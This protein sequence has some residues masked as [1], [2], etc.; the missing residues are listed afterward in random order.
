MASDLG[1]QL[2]AW[3]SG[4]WSEP[5]RLPDEFDDPETGRTIDLTSLQFL[6]QEGQGLRVI[7]RDQ[8]GGGD[9]WFLEQAPGATTAQLI[10]T[11]TPVPASVW[12]EPVTLD[13]GDAENPVYAYDPAMAADPNVDGRFHLIWSQPAEDEPEG[14]GRSIVYARWDILD[15]ERYPRPVTLFTSLEAKADRPALAA[16]ETGRLHLVWSG[17]QIGE[18]MYSRAEAESAFNP[19]NWGD[20]RM[21]PMARPSGSWPV[22]AVG[23]DGVVHVVYVVPLNEERGIYHTCS[24]DGG[25]SWSESSTIGDGVASG[26]PMVDHPALSIGADGTLHVAWSVLPLPGSL[27]PSELYYAHSGDC[28]ANWSEPAKLA[29]GAVDWPQLAAAGSLEVHLIYAETAGRAVPQHRWSA[30]GGQTWSRSNWI[31][32]LEGYEGP[33]RLTVDSAGR[34][35]LA[36]VTESGGAGLSSNESLKLVHQLWDGERWTEMEAG[37]SLEL[38]GD[39]LLPQA[40]GSTADDYLGFVLAGHTV[41]EDAEGEEQT[42]EQILLLARSLSLPEVLPTPL[43]TLTPTPTPLPQPS[44]TPTLAPTPTPD[45]SGGTSDQVQVG[46]VS[47]PGSWAG[48]VVG[49]V[50]AAAIV[51]VSFLVAVLVVR[52]RK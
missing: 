29:D 28:G 46:P 44:A 48:L 6:L 38:S 12:G 37:P 52:R 15:Q 5:Y 23:R 10:V 51:L 25:D 19:S 41:E 18:I 14:P 26:W 9:V 47:L 42:Q 20:P 3:D 2:L 4:A 22:M 33:V 45:L 35:H 50:P 17:N 21:L 1:D 49:A 7:G 30:D 31:P 24:A 8:A 11:P 34:V 40:F 43:P 16:D 32:A 13:L 36:A 39:S 27:L